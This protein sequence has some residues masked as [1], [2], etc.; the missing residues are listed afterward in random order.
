[1]SRVGMLTIGQAPRPDLV[2][3]FARLREDVEIVE[4]GALDDLTLSTL[5]HSPVGRYPLTTRLTDGTVVTLDEQTL[6]PLV[7]SA[8]DRLE[9]EDVAATLLLCAAPFAGIRGRRPVVRPFD[10]VAQL[11]GT[12]G[13]RRVAVLVPVEAQVGPARHKF[14]AAGFEPAVWVADVASAPE[15]LPEWLADECDT[16]GRCEAV[17]LDYVGHRE[18]DVRRLQAVLDVPVVDLGLTAAALLATLV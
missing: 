5:P 16:D 14:E 6:V 3:P 17:V 13:I 15:R 9:D 1:M 8:L 11:L 10:V 7:R 2:E 12:S 18:E 4:A